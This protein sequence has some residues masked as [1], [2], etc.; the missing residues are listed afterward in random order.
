MSG[1][2][3]SSI[4]PPSN[5][6]NIPTSN[7]DRQ[8]ADYHPSPWNDYFLQYAS[9]S[10]EIDDEMKRSIETLK[11]EVRKML[12]SIMG[13]P[14]MKAEMVDSI[15]RL[16]LSYHFEAEIDEVLKQIHNDSVENNEITHI[17]DLHSVALLF[18]LLRQ[19]GY[20]TS[21]D[22]FN[23][24][25]DEKGNFSET[26]TSD[27]EG[28]I[29]LYEA[30]H[31]SIHGEDILDKALAFTTNH[32]QSITAESNPFVAA[33]LNHVLNQCP[34]RGIPRLEARKYISIYHLHPSH[35]EVLLTLAKLDFNALQKLHQKEI[36]NICKWWNSLDVPRNLS[37][38]RGRIVESFFWGLVVIFEPQ[39]SKG[40]SVLAKEISFLTLIDDT[41]DVYGTLDELELFT[42]SIERWD[43]SCL[44]DLPGYMKLLYKE[45]LNL[46]EKIDDEDMGKEGRSHNVD[47]LIKDFKKIVQAYMTETR[48]LQRNYVPTTEEYL[49]IATITTCFTFLSMSSFICMGDIVT[50][51]VLKW[52]ETH[53]KI[54]RAASIIGRLMDDIVSNEFEQK[55][56]HI[57]SLL[58][59]YM[60]EHG[61]SRQEAIDELR[62]M[63]ERA[64]KDINEECL[65]P[66]QV[67]MPFLMILLNLARFMDVMYKEADNYTHAGGI[68]KEFITLQLVD[69]VPI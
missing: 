48:W 7:S 40:R 61:V 34:Y 55:R 22:V 20:P 2:A 63:L 46:F 44:D 67:P 18:R 32:L 21:A 51:D 19:H 25:K 42:A 45:L 39:Y 35:N 6:K 43:T 33:K 31:L 30:S 11:E 5:P 1:N 49:K 26:L 27:V 8:C 13:K 53:P 14:L 54:L 28:M 17:E 23:K 66:T 62:K 37:Y 12:V 60:K 58:E 69:P 57:A 16:G 15:Q 68:M 47:Y 52:V 41:Y 59:C 3:A 29:S 10:L 64:W 38:A 56:K 9:D 24:F 4:F 50:E 36:G 65:R